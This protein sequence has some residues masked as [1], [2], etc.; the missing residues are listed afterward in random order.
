MKPFRQ[1]DYVAN[2][3]YFVTR[4]LIRSV[5]DRFPKLNTLSTWTLG[6][7]GL[8]AVFLFTN[9]EKLNTYLKPVAIS[10]IL[11]LFVASIVAGL[12]QKFYAMRVESI[13]KL[14]DQLTAQLISAFNSL[15][16]HAGSEAKIALNLNFPIEHQL[17]AETCQKIYDQTAT[18][19]AT[20]MTEFQS[21]SPWPFSHF[22]QAGIDAAK[23][24]VLHGLKLGY[25]WFT[26]ELVALFV[27]LA[28][29]VLTLI[30]AALSL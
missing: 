9:L 6:A 20:A 1:D 29:L 16:I 5:I 25:K 13:S 7:T 26:C 23:T 3:S 18:I 12:V 10:W 24:D 14:D 17:P 30:V 2:H 11:W 28:A 15:A 27:Q 8:A 21:S 4:T 19:V 22:V